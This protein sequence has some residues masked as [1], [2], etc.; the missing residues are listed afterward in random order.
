MVIEKLKYEDLS[1]YKNMI[2][3]CFGGSNSL[4]YYRENYRENANYDILVAKK[5]D[6]IVGSITF[7]RIDLFTYSFQPAIE[8]FNVAV[9]NEYRGQKI[10]QELF[11]NIIK[12]A[13][14]NSYNSIFL[15]CLDTAIPAHKLYESLGFK[16]MNSVKYSLNLK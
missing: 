14:D 1:L 7:Y 11:N 6:I 9:L 3:E 5:D 15:T 8:I 13:K 4:E 10:A 12:Y 16:K 2:D